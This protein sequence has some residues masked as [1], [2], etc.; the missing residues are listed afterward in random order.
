MLRRP[1]RSTRTD[2]LV[3][4][5]TRFR[6]GGPDGG[7]GQG[8]GRVLRRGAVTGQQR[9]GGTDRVHVDAREHLDLQ[10]VE[11][12]GLLVAVLH[13]RDVGAAAGADV[14]VPV[15]RGVPS[16]APH[17]VG[18]PSRI[19]AEPAVVAGR[20]VIVEAG[21]PPVDRKGTRTNS[22]P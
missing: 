1:P 8:G 5:T 7:V 13:H 20:P 4:Y 19:D 22:S 2:T 3:P 12:A 10:V 11:L 17:A 9:Q 14:G 15:G 18:P 16:L 21:D 6:S